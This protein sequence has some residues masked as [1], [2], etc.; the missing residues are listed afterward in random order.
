[1]LLTM[2]EYLLN[3]MHMHM[4]LFRESIGP[5]SIHSFYHRISVELHL[6]SLLEG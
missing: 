1:M 6:L 3:G 2:L 4:D 5:G